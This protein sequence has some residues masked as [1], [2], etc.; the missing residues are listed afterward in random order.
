MS[1]RLYIPVSSPANRSN[2]DSIDY[3]NPVNRPPRDGKTL[4]TPINRKKKKKKSADNSGRNKS[5]K[6]NRQAHNSLYTWGDSDAGG[7][8]SSQDGDSNEENNP[9]SVVAKYDIKEKKPKKKDLGSIPDKTPK[10]TTHFD[11]FNLSTLD[12]TVKEKQV[13]RDQKAQQ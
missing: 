5:Q 10:G 1:E 3:N 13:A 4:A 9:D 11:T 2:S 7:D 8:D 6:K 12:A